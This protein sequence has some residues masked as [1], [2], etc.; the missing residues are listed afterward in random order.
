MCP[1]LGTITAT[2][3]TPGVYTYQWFNLATGSTIATSNPAPLPTGLY[4]LTLTNAAG[5]VYGSKVQNDAQYILYTSFTATLTATPANCTDGSVTVSAVG[6]GAVLP[7][8]YHWSNGATTS[9]ITGL[10][11]GN[12]E[13][14]ITDALGCKASSAPSTP[15]SPY[16][17]FVPQTTVISAPFTTTPASCAYADGAISVTGAGGTAPYTYLWNNGSTAASQTGIPAG[18]YAVTVTDANGCTGQN[19]AFLGT[20]TS[21]SA[22]TSSSP[23]LCTTPNGN[24]TVIPSGGTAPYSIQWYTTPAQSS[25]TATLLSA[26]T[27]T[28]K[29][30]DAA[31]CVQTGVVT[32]PSVNNIIATTSSMSPYCTLANGSISVAPTGGAAPYT[33]LWSNGSTTASIA[34]L[35]PGT[36]SVRVTDAMSCKVTVPFT[37]HSYTPVNVGLSVAPASCLFA[38]DATI[39]A[40][41]YGGTAPYS[42]GWSTGGTTSTISGLSSGHFWMTATDATGCTV[43]RNTYVGYDAAATSCYCTIEGTV[44]SDSVANCTQDAGEVGIPHVQIYCSGIGYTYT[45]A[46]GHYSFKVP[47]GSYTVTETVQPF[48]SLS[49]CQLNGIAVTAIASTGCVNTV[50]FANGSTPVHN[51]RISTSTVTPAVPGE[52]MIQQI[53]IINEGTVNEDSV[54]TT[55]KTDGQL[56]APWFTP[57]GIFTASGNHYTT[58]G[59]PS[60]APGEVQVFDVAYNVPANMPVN[61]TVTNMDTVTYNQPTSTWTD[62]HT[63][64][65]NVCDH[66]ATVVASYDANFKEVYPKGTDASGLITTS[67]SVLEYTIHFQN[68]TGWYAQNIVIIDTLDGDFDWASLH[69]VYESHACQAFVYQ[70]GA[71][72]V[73]KFTFTNINMPPQTMDDLRSNGM[74]T[75]TVKTATGLAAGTQLK[76]RASIYFDNNEPV[77]TNTTLN[78]V[79]TGTGPIIV[80]NTPA[81]GNNSFVV[82]P[83]PA[84]NSFHAVIN[85][86]KTTTA[87]MNVTDVTGKTLMSKTMTLQAGTQTLTTDVNQLAPGMYFVNVITDGKVQTQKLAIVK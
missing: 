51:L 78:T 1:A 8:S 62:D 7:Y 26:G 67:D 70:S 48:R 41:P 19:A 83:N 28:Y 24:A 65:N 11:S 59:F 13:V 39:T 21:I 25:T 76:N 56:F 52:M 61:T 77:V 20:A 36:Y 55:Y 79:G 34:G 75:Y 23:S 35:M 86:E 69:P 49:P 6:A 58:S 74:V 63:P 17:A 15:Y 85:T 18:V 44:Y 14:E 33:Y 47:S 46:A 38:N 72:K 53:A 87:V 16:L 9:S 45:D 66:K 5:C 32:V 2:V 30:T 50:N 80:K 42:F 81:V 82:Y 27:Y 29:I 40:T 60:L 64:W 4:G 3:G 43:R 84:S 57:S 37:L 10:S 68:T 73:A 71:V 31:G 54:F 22:T 12:Y